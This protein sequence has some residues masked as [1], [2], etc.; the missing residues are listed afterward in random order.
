MAA[1]PLSGGLLL[2]R[3]GAPSLFTKPPCQQDTPTPVP[4]S[5]WAEAGPAWWPGRGPRGTEH[6][7]EQR[8][9]VAGRRW[10]GRW[11]GCGLQ[12]PLYLSPHREVSM[13]ACRVRAPPPPP[14]PRLG[15]SP[16]SLQAPQVRTPYRVGASTHL[17]ALLPTSPG[18]PPKLKTGL[19]D[20][21]GVGKGLPNVKASAYSSYPPEYGLGDPPPP[22]GLLQPP[23]LAPWQPS[24][25]DGAPA[26]PAQPR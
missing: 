19:R 26:T 15:A 20:G 11:P 9:G 4:G 16:S 24:R 1:C 6:L 2:P 21:S 17:P 23:T 22:P 5:R 7:G 13:V 18:P 3:P 10:A 25:G 12:V 8:E 14:D